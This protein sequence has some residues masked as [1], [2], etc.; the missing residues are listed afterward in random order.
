MQTSKREW[1]ALLTKLLSLFKNNVEVSVSPTRVELRCRDVF[2]SVPAQL[3]VTLGSGTP[4]LVAVGDRPLAN[5]P[6]RAIDV[7]GPEDCGV[8][9]WSREY[10]LVLFFRA[11]LKM[12]HGAGPFAVRP[13]VQ[14]RGASSVAPVLGP[15]SAILLKSAILQAGAWACEVGD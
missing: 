10:R 1:R 8:P 7:F 9:E 2:V 13:R 3:Y 5:E 4:R 12:L 6:S 11:S 14:V 15:A